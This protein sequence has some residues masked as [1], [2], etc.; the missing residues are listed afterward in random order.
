MLQYESL[1][2][3]CVGVSAEAVDSVMMPVRV[4]FAIAAAVD[5]VGVAASVVV[6][7][8]DA[9][10]VDACVLIDTSVANDDC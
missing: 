6:V 9:V 2:M 4:A 1:A 7:V 3:V 8:M 10:A 5:K